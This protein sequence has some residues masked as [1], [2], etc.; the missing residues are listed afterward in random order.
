MQETTNELS[1]VLSLNFD[2][3]YVVTVRALGPRGDS[4]VSS[5]AFFTTEPEGV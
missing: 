5:Q 4:M 2:T 3:S 1:I